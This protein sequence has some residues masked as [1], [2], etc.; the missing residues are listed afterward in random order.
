VAAVTYR[1]LQASTNLALDEQLSRAQIAD[2]LL[3]AL[4]FAFHGVSASP[5]V[6]S[7]RVR[8]SQISNEA[9]QPGVHVTRSQQQ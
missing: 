1:A 9:V 5:K 6:K 4:V 2:Y 3:E 7:D 8:S